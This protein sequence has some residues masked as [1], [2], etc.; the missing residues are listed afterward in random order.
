[1][2]QYFSRSVWYNDMSK[3]NC[4]PFQFNLGKMNILIVRKVND[5]KCKQLMI[6]HLTLIHL[7]SIFTIIISF[8]SSQW[9]FLKEGTGPSIA[10]STCLHPKNMVSTLFLWHTGRHLILQTSMSLQLVEQ[11]YNESFH[12]RPGLCI[13]NWTEIK[14]VVN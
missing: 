3:I 1:M 6:R 10:K 8:K 2:Y 14:N 7:L 4:I 11:T 9:G 5:I 12:S 13:F